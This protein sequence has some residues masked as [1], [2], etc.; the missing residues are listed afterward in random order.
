V[1]RGELLAPPFFFDPEGATLI[2]RV[3]HP[4]L[5]ERLEDVY[6]ETQAFRRQFS[7][8]VVP[9]SGF[10]SGSNRVDRFR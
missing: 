3:R 4:F 1:K 7:N 10:L 6:A 2:F 8:R 9:F 5:L